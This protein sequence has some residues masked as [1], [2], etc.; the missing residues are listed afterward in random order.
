[1]LGAEN[2][3]PGSSSLSP[4]NTWFDIMN[5]PTRTEGLDPLGRFEKEV[6]RPVRIEDLAL[7]Y[8]LSLKQL[9][10]HADGDLASVSCRIARSGLP[11]LTSI[12]NYL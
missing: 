2:S 7:V 1:M 11:V 12:K 4:A 10:P 6:S 5:V 9:Q 3:R 8:G